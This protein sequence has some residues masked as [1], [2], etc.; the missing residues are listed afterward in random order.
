MIGFLGGTG[1]EGRD[2]A[3]RLALAG[4]DVIIGSRDGSR[5]AAVAEEVAG[6]A[7]GAVVEGALNEETAAAGRR[8]VHSCAY[9]AQRPTI[10]PLAGHL[11]GKVVVGVTVPV[12]F[13]KGAASIQPVPDGSEESDP[14]GRHRGAPSNA[15][16]VRQVDEIEELDQGRTSRN[17]DRGRTRQTSRPSTSHPPEATARPATRPDEG[18][19]LA[20]EPVGQAASGRPRAAATPLLLYQGLKAPD[21]F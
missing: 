14:A 7:P 4:E 10:E 21:S 3:L 6:L 12:R 1:P 16:H 17:S 2:L 18:P 13:S 8:R 20:G 19:E 9:S 15:G 5:A 11:A